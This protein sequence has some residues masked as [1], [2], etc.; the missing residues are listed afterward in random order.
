MVHREKML[1]QEKFCRST[2]P[3]K[4]LLFLTAADTRHG[5]NSEI[6]FSS[7]NDN[8]NVYLMT[9]NSA[10]P[11]IN[12]KK[13]LLYLENSLEKLLSPLEVRVVVVEDVVH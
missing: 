2:Y 1:M 4:Y 7:K 9:H 8:F 11:A 5:K 6:P 12:K 10:K 13:R 3:N